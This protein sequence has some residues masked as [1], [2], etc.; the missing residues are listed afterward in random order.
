MR[1]KNA[2]WPLCALAAV[3]ILALCAS[4]AYM[5]GKA[6]SAAVAIL[7][8]NVSESFTSYT[9]G[10]Q[11]KAQLAL[12][13][14]KRVELLRMTIPNRVSY[15]EVSIVMP[16]EY[17]YYADMKGSW[18]LTVEG[19]TLKV[20]A[21]ALELMTPAPDLAGTMVVIDKSIFD[22]GRAQEKLDGLK[23]QAAA[24]LRAR[25]LS[26]EALKEVRE[27]ARAELASFISAWLLSGRKGGIDRILIRFAGEEKF[28]S[29]GYS[30]PAY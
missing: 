19:R 12:C 28:P 4:A 7:G 9:L 24:R 15:S 3:A 22:F 5:V 25:G 13:S 27:T 11:G 18:T 21:P 14:A 10:L 16:V 8:G 29:V 23:A 30:S 6:S 1:L 26:P 17:T 20:S 2:Y